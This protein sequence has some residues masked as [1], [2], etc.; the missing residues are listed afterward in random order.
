V[1]KNV[2]DVED[3]EKIKSIRRIFEFVTLSL[4]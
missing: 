2:I 3:C 4:I 1:L